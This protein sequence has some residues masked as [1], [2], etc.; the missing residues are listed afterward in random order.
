MLKFFFHA[1]AAALWI[2]PLAAKAELNAPDYG[3]A[4][5]LAAVAYCSY[6]VSELDEDQGRQRAAR[7][8]AA[9]AKD[10][11][12]LKATLGEKQEIEAYLQLDSPE[13][14][15]LLAR[16]KDGVALAFRGTITPPIDPNGGLFRAAANSAVK[17]NTRAVSGLKTFVADW[18]NDAKAGATSQGRHRGFDQSWQALFAHLSKD[19]RSAPTTDCSQFA[20]FL[21]GLDKAKG[22]KLYITGHSK[23]GA[24]AILAAIDIP[25]GFS[26]APVTYT[27]AAAKALTADKAKDVAFQ[28][29]ALWRF[30]RADDIVPALAPDSSVGLWRI[31]GAP[32]GHAGGLVMFDG[33]ATPKLS[34]QP[35]KGV[36][37]PDDSDRI[38][39]V[40]KGF[41]RSPFDVLTDAWRTGDFVGTLTN[42]LDL[43]E[44]GCRKFVD[45][46]FA[47]FTEARAQAPQANKAGS[48]FV[49]RIKDGDGDILWGYRDWCNLVKVAP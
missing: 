40:L 41:V 30:E 3:R 31:V 22:E 29:G 2:A 46:H 28:A 42:A 1:A 11:D 23:G 39:S 9:A 4:Y 33:L 27:F 18:L 47:V 43:P 45:S 44:T 37:Q 8:L 13:N 32:Y 12:A 6:A 24:L 35:A 34:A 14:A 26:V 36:Y 17:Y 5:A 19:C 21:A 20:S 48:L 16:I 38:L 15:Y 10:D 49:E 7:C 25:Q